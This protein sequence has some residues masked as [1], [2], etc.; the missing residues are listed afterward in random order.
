MFRLY[1][2]F[3]DQN[4]SSSNKNISTQECENIAFIIDT[5]IVG[6]T[7]IFDENFQN[8]YWK[9]FIFIRQAKVFNYIIGLVLN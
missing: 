3:I 9:D 5:I 6:G 2:W 4:L 7:S 8:L 1:L